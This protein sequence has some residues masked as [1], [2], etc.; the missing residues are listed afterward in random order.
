MISY[1]RWFRSHGWL[2]E[3]VS[4]LL[5]LR[6]WKGITSKNI[7]ENTLTNPISNNQKNWTLGKIS[8]ISWVF[9]NLLIEIWSTA[10]VLVWTGKQQAQGHQACSSLA[11]KRTEFLSDPNVICSSVQFFKKVIPQFSILRWWTFIL[12]YPI[13]NKTECWE[14]LAKQFEIWFLIL[15]VY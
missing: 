5:V 15:T 13:I 7:I 2:H 3:N 14:K 8:K 9:I 1:S 11:N 6:V 12:L 4:C 10:Q